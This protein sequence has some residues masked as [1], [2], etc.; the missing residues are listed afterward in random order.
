MKKLFLA[1]YF[2]HVAGLLPHFIE[3]D[4]AGKKVV[5]IPTAALHEEMTF[6]VDT[7]K[8]ALQQLGFIIEELDI[9][10]VNYNEIKSSLSNA[11]AIFV[12][13]GNTFFLLQELK[14]SGADKLIVEHIHQGK[15][16]IATSAGSIVLANDIGFAADTDSPEAAPFLNGNFTG[17]SVVDFYVFPH[18]DNGYYA[19]ANRQTLDKYADTLDFK[20]I[21]DN[22]VVTVKGEK[23]EILTVKQADNR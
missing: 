2:T 7:D 10:S 11:D 14:R 4:C 16:Y 18:Y 19:E 13:G 8:A 1:S 5:I 20:L 3:E 12:G 21:T 9:S 23:V 6:Y 15:P 17:L 22:Q